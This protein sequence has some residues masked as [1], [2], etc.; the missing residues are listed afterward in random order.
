MWQPL[1]GQPIS[2][3]ELHAGLST[4]KRYVVDRDANIE[5]NFLREVAGGHKCIIDKFS[6]A[7][8]LFE[9]DVLQQ[10]NALLTVKLLASRGSVG[11]WRRR[12]PALLLEEI[13]SVSKDHTQADKEVAAQ[14]IQAYW[15]DHRRSPHSLCQGASKV[16]PFEHKM[17]M[18]LRIA[19]GRALLEL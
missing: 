18:K 11:S 17:C 9:P 13:V 7:S 1:E 6:N 10:I 8:A 4:L 16:V 3:V 2:A 12:A 15:R 19:G 14:F 5:R